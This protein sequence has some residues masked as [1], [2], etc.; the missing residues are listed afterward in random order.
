MKI[1]CLGDSL[2]TEYGVS[3]RE[4]WIFR[5]Q[6]DGVHEWIGAGICGDTTGG[7]LARLGSDVLSRRPDAAVFMGG[8]NDIVLSGSF[9][10]ARLNLMAMVHQA[11]AAGIRPVV[12]VPPLIRSVPPA[13]YP[14]SFGGDLARVSSEY[15][16]WLRVFCRSFGLRLLDFAAAFE[17]GGGHLLYQPDGLHPN[18]AGHLVMADAVRASRYFRKA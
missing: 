8:S 5:L 12:A 2:S 4:S 10:S 13:W 18:P 1:V 6:Q 7:M 9:E 17:L 11:A 16:A 3:P 14:A 15:A